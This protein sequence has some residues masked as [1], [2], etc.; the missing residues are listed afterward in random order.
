[1]YATRTTAA[2]P[3]RTVPVG[4]VASM[5]AAC[6]A[7]DDSC[8]IADGVAANI[9]DTTSVVIGWLSITICSASS[10]SMLSIHSCRKYE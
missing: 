5:P 9:A 8:S 7:S 1:M 2:V 6:T 10:S 4:R 3:A